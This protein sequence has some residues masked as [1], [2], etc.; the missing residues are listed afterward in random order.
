MINIRKL[1]AVDMA[2][3]GARVIVAEFA[4]GIVIPLV[5]GLISIRA[6]L[7]AVVQSGW[8]TAL[9]FWLIGIAA[10]YFPLFIYAVVIARGGTV[11]EEGQ[12]ELA[13][14]KRYGIQQAIILIPFLVVVLALVQ[15][16]RQQKAK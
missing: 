4:L 12:P 16:S 15:E 10:N 8:A 9:G 14:V 5:L 2:L 7:F 3:H 11:K 1:A 6:V 13:H